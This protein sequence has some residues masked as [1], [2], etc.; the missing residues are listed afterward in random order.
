MTE[1][2]QISRAKI[3]NNVCRHLALKEVAPD[4]LQQ[5]LHVETSSRR[6]QGRT[7]AREKRKLYHGET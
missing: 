1:K 6:A 2:N 4:S 5:R 3:P 7:G